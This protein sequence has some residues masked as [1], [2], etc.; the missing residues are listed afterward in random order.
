MDDAVMNITKLKTI[1]NVQI[2]VHC[3]ATAAAKLTGKCV[4]TTQCIFKVEIDRIITVWN[5]HL[6]M[7][8]TAH[9]KEKVEPAQV[10]RLS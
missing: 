5:P 10:L 4:T 7:L 6:I 8:P 2:S 3:I 1:S 9:L